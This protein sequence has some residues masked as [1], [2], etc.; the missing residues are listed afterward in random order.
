MLKNLLLLVCVLLQAAYGDFDYT[1]DN[2][3]FTIAQDS[4]LPVENKDYLYN[5]DRLRFR[6]DYT[7]E[8]YFATLT[9]DLVN[10]LGH[11]YIN[12]LSYSYV[13]EQESDTPFKTQTSYHNYGEGEVYAKLYRLYGGYE[14]GLNRVVL[15]L[16]NITMGVGR[17]WTPSNLF[18]PI[19]SY[20]FEPDEVFGV[21]AITYTRHL[22][23]TSKLTA[24]ISQK[25]DKSYKYA[26]R[27]KSYLAFADV[28]VNAISSDETK[29]LAYELEGNLADTGIELRSEGAYIKSDLLTSLVQK[30]EREFF[31]GIIGADYGFENGVTLVTEALY[32][33]DSFNYD[34]IL[35]NRRSEIFSNLHYSKFYVGTTLSY[36]INIF[37]DASLVYIESFNKHNSGFVSPSLSY[38]LNDFNTLT[39]GAMLYDGR[40]GSEFADVGNSYYFKYVLSF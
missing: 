5:Y 38:T 2:T 6:G 14:D 40:R 35:L 27:Y 9:A 24:V 19:N 13:K 20:A 17:I 15:G 12:S 29:M 21:A 34:E 32:S 22:S 7:Q 23:D 36:S 30:Q 4:A 25:K 26:A 16:Q 33:S 18:N 11:E 1:I 3:N 31:Q 10:Y 37:L 28:A 8:S 39:L